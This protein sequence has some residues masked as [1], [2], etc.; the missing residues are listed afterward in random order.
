MNSS[1]QINGVSSRIA[2]MP[3]STSPGPVNPDQMLSQ[4]L[5]ITLNSACEDKP[6]RITVSNSCT[7][8]GIFNQT[9]TL[10]VDATQLDTLIDKL[11]R[12]RR[13]I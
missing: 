10:D 3:R 9:A 6:I 2:L 5:D 13:L 12:I 7:G 11:T 1:L 8:E 4:T